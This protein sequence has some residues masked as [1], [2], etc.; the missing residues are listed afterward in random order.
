M[1]R[2]AVI[3]A[4][5]RGGVK[6]MGGEGEKRVGIVS[7]CVEVRGKKEKIRGGKKKTK[8][9]F[10]FRICVRRERKRGVGFGG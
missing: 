2:G 9:A 4:V 10:S 8:R 5:R 6:G 3:P 1:V 7:V